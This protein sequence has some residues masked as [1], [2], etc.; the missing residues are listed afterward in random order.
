MLTYDFIVVKGF[1]IHHVFHIAEY[2]TCFIQYT[3]IIC[4]SIHKHIRYHDLVDIH[5]ISHLNSKVVKYI[6]IQISM[7]YNEEMHKIKL[8]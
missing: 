3:S 5:K 7:N 1:F 6:K 8:F 4:K 2:A